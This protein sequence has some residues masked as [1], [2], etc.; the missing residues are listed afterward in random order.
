MS[1]RR[2]PDTPEDGFI[3]DPD[4]SFVDDV[5]CTVEEA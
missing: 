5:A 1:E 3:P 2:L 4:L